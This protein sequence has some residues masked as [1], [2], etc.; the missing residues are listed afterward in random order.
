LAV[1]HGD[2]Q[3]HSVPH[4]VVPERGAA[5]YVRLSESAAHARAQN[6]EAHALAHLIS[7]YY[8]CLLRQIGDQQRNKGEESLA[9]KVQLAFQPVQCPYRYSTSCSYPSRRRT[10]TVTELETRPNSMLQCAR[11]GR[12]VWYLTSRRATTMG[13]FGSLLDRAW[14]RVKKPAGFSE[15]C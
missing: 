15:N 7:L 13:V 12:R 9:Q 10:D 2:G 14:I 4:S 1:R 6:T 5:E 8:C 3:K 11:W